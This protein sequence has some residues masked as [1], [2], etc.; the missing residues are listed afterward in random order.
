MYKT[1]QKILSAL[2]YHK[3]IIRGITNTSMRKN[4]HYVLS[5]IF[6]EYLHRR[7][8]RLFKQ[9]LEWATLPDAALK[10]MLDD[11]EITWNE[12]VDCHSCA[13]ANVQK[14]LSSSWFNVCS[15]M[16][17]TKYKLVIISV[18]SI[19]K[20]TIL[21]SETT[22]RNLRN[23]LRCEQLDSSCFI[24]PLED[25]VI[26]FA[27]EA[28]ISLIANPYNCATETLDVM[29]QN[30]FLH[31]RFLHVNDIFRIDA[32]EHAQDRFYS[33]GFTGI[34][35]MYFTVQA[36]KV[37]RNARG[38]SNSVNSCYVV[39]GES[40]VIQEAQVHDYIPHGRVCSLPDAFLQQNRVAPNHKY[41][42]AL[43]EPLKHLESCITLFLRKDLANIRLN[44]RPVFL[45]K[46]PRGCGKYELVRAT[47]KRMGLNFLGV[48]FVEVQTLTS[49]QTEA[50]L[51]IILQNAQK[52]VPCIL[53][54]NNVQVFGKTAEGQKDERVISFFS[55]EITA[56]Y[57]RR[58]KFPLIIVAASDE[59]DVSVE[60]Q[61]IFI[62]TI[63][64]K[65]LNQSK[66]AELIFWLLF[67]RNLKTT[68]DLSKVA[69]LCSD[70]KV[71]DLLALSLHA[72]KFRCKSMSHANQ[73]CTLTLEQEDFDRAYEYMQSVYSD[74]K[75][76]PHVPE[77]HWEDIGGLADLKHEI[78]RRIQLPLLNAFGFGQSG[79]LLYG[80]PGTGK[81]LLA[82]A[83][84]TEYQ[85]HFLSIKGS[86]VLNMYVG[87]SEKNVRQIFKR[88]RSAAPCIVF[89]D[90]LDSLAPNRGRS[91]DS[92]GVMDRVVSQLLA[93]MDGLE[94]SGSI[95]II[96]AT[97][98][99]DL[100]DPALLRPGRFDKMLYVGIHSD[101]AS[102][103]SV[104]EAQ[105][106]KFM[107]QEN[108]RELERITE[109]LPNNVTGADLYSVT[110]NAWLNAVRE[111]LAKH[112]ETEIIN[113]DYSVEEEGVIKDNVIVELR[114]FSDAIHNLVP[115]VTDEEIKRYNR[116]Q[117]DH[118]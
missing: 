88:A 7:F 18:P 42:S 22:E 76:A 45:V 40:T 10:F 20:N 61:R 58:R 57:N 24:L 36:L 81:T 69:G 31:P 103:F 51:R 117:V 112:Q 86:E 25:D 21:I 62:E 6:L 107:F 105:T 64:M 100:I 115:S 70:F 71:A 92:G 28:R 43:M 63:H 59:T 68:A 90:E 29:L 96:G 95:F 77:V 44:V 60:L 34:S 50:K 114:H 104:L 23:A 110:S 46:G 67:N 97:N 94:E 73:K 53:Y 41:P 89:F 78:I 16:S 118:C 106:R 38:H 55:T 52:C 35:V 12:Y 17:M 30:Y 83:V 91:G 49:A 99:P 113:K 65:H 32:K 54:L 84:A 87:Q 116:M 47:S 56:L 75:G 111:V 1:R 14:K 4:S 27:S 37:N 80:P 48:D 93:E 74:S 9:D 26:E 33:S 39:R 3:R 5:Y 66:R 11:L 101:R 8:Q 82:K 108:G 2:L 98:R 15:M 102:K 13:I 109:Q 19:S 85:M 79:L 72:T